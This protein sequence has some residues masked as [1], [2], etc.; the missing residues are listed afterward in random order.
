VSKPVREKTRARISFFL[1][2][3]IAACLVCLILLVPR[4]GRFPEEEQPPPQGEAPIDDGVAPEE[5]PPEARP[6]APRP[7]VLRISV[8]ID[9][10]GYSL[11]TLQPFLEYPGPLTVAVLPNLPLS[12]EA[13]RRVKEAGKELIVHLPMEPMGAED[14]GP[15]AIMTGQ[16]EETIRSLLAQSFDSVPG[17]RGA[18]NHMG[19]R[20]MA[21]PGVMQAVMRY[22]A[23][24]GRFFLDSGT[25]DDSRAPESAGRWGVPLLK[26]GVFLDNEPGEIASRLQE[27]FE[28]A[29]ANGAAV[30]IGHVKSPEILTEL[31]RLEPR[32]RREGAE[33]VALGELLEA[34]GEG[35]AP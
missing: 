30:L 22:L 8:V 7:P 33:I 15:G 2:S 14:P 9:D 1:L 26:R 11:E 31:G 20:A 5:A 3:V 12:R 32:W 17:A 21:D 35:T 24:T 28:L 23:E 27:G 29:R 19:S 16:D 10:A 6:Q 34:A 18:N 13:A 4:C 25:T